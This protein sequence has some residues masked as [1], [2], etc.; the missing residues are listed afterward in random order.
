[1]F[2]SPLI[3]PLLSSKEILNIPGSRVR[4]STANSLISIAPMHFGS[5]IPVSHM[6]VRALRQPR[7][8]TPS[9][10]PTGLN[11]AESCERRM[12]LFLAY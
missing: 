5:S 1:M 8:A 4:A 12:R 11:S 7:E 2:S 3:S 10:S 9:F 6:G